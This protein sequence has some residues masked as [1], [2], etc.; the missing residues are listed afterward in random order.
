MWQSLT[1]SK[2]SIKCFRMIQLIF[3]LLWDNHRHIS[4]HEKVPQFMPHFIYYACEWI[5]QMLSIVNRCHSRLKLG[6]SILWL[7]SANCF[8]SQ[9][10][11][12]NLTDLR[13]SFAKFRAELDMH[14]LL[15]EVWY[16][17]TKQPHFKNVI[18]CECPKLQCWSEWQITWQNL[19]LLQP[20]SCSTFS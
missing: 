2:L 6:K 18:T 12:Q 1:C 7:N 11:F 17:L 13:S 10:K 14:T 8:F 3:P 5:P 16:F 15:S 19:L 9:S 20:I 4:L